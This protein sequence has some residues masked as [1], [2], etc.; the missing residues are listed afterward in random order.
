MP[1][2]ASIVEGHGV[3]E[4]V[5]LLVRRVARIVAPDIPLHVPRPIRVR[6]DEIVK[7]QELERAIEL[8]ARQ[9]G[10]GGAI[11]VLLDAD[12]DC[13]AELAPTLLARATQ[14]RKDFVIGLALAKFEYEAWFLAAAESLRGHRN[15]ALDLSCPP[16][17]EDVRGAKE[18]PPVI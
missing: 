12:D 4:S 1:A 3:V 13:P 2:I 6:R 9:A 16:N 17:P 5:P 14:A 7:T 18:W 11:F 8:A 15:L 10:L